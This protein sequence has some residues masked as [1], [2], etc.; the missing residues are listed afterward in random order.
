VLDLHPAAL[1]QLVIIAAVAVGF[2]LLD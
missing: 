1:W 2:V